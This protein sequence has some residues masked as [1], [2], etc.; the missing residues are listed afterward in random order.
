M[1]CLVCNGLG[2]VKAAPV[3]RRVT[4]EGEKDFVSW[5]PHDV[6]AVL[7][8]RHYTIGG[9]DVNDWNDEYRSALAS[10]TEMDRYLSCHHTWAGNHCVHCGEQ[11]Q[12]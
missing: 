11:V 6:D 2:W 4:A 10:Y 7:G 5:D 1:M 9:A 8:L 12:P 3:V